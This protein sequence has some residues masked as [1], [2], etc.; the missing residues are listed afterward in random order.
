MSRQARIEP[1][2]AAKDLNDKITGW[3]VIDESQPENENVVSEH[4]SQAE[5]I[6]AAEEFEQRED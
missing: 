4:E 2:F 6:R 1:V 3:V 5:A